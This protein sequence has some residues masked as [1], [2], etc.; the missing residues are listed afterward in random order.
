MGRSVNKCPNLNLL[1]LSDLL[2]LP[3]L[4]KPTR[5][6]K[7]SE[8]CVLSTLESCTDSAPE[9]VEKAGE[10][11]GRWKRKMFNTSSTPLF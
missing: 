8:P 7:G 1:P 6:T 2:L 4:G 10:H 5:K 3:P 11:I 9:L